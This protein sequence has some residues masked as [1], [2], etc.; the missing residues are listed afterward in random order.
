[1]PYARKVDANHKAITDA[2]RA[3]GWLVADTSRLKGFVDLV[4]QKPGRT[5]LV[6]VKTPRGKLTEAQVRL[7]EQGWWIHVLRTVD[8]ALAL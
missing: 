7:S 8:D 3:C 6:E 1:M 2:L 5:V 4:A